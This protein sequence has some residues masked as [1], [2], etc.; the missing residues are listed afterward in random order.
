MNIEVRVFATLRRYIPGIGVGEP[1]RFDLPEGTTLED[2]RVQ[3]GLPL[4]EI[5]IVMRNGVQAELSEK[6][7]DGDRIAY[8]P[9]VAGG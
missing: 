6:V 9:A 8:A 5:K 3:L 2:L 1:I 7:A 4:E